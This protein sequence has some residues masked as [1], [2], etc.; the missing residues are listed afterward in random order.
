M[1]Y[2]NLQAWSKE[3]G[4]HNVPHGVGAR[5]CCGGRP[6]LAYFCCNIMNHESAWQTF[7]DLQDLSVILPFQADSLGLMPHCYQWRVFL[8]CM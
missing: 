7:E 2:P 8:Y 4:E 6:H 1:E 3:F 5:N